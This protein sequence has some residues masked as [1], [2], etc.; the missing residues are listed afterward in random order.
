MIGI[1]GSGGQADE[2]RAILKDEPLF[3]AV[4]AA[5][6][7]GRSVAIEGLSDEERRADVVIAVGAPALKKHFEEIWGKDT[8]VSVIAE[9]A[10]VDKTSEIGVGTIIAPGAIVTTNVKVGKHVL[11]NTSCTISHDAKIGDFSCISPGVNVG[12]KVSISE[13]VFV[14]IGATIKNGVSIAEGVVIGA[15]AVVLH[16]IKEINSVY[17]GVPAKK[18]KQ[19]N[20]WLRAI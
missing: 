20:G 19:N 7:S 11:L 18:I 3:Y 1:L 4:E 16:D 14:G 13:G 6:A 2:V 17:A 12:G 15:G 8:Y 9:S 10:V 5:Y